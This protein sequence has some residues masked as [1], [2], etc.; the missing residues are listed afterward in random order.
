MASAGDALRFD[1]RAPAPTAGPA[2]STLLG[3]VN[4]DDW[5]GHPAGTLLVVGVAGPPCDAGGEMSAVVTALR[6]ADGHGPARGSADFDAPGLGGEIPDGL[7]E[8]THP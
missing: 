7:A 4:A 6:N 3:A 5:R 1:F 2:L 8:E